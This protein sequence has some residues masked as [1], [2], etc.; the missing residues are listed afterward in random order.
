MVFIVFILFVI[1][2]RIGEMVLSR[3]N[4]VWL[5]QHGAIETGQRHYPAI[6]A[7]HMLFFVSL[8]VEYSTKQTV[9]FNVF[10]LVL[11]FILQAGKIWIVFSLG[12]FWNTKIYRI[13]DAPLIKKGPYRYF[14][15]PN[16]M[17]VVI[18][19]AVIPLMF[20]LVYTAIAF[21]LLN[22]IVLTVRIYEENKVI[23]K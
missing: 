2:L 11:F 17:I 20:Q 13:P 23:A 4:E 8:I 6:I 18:E 5:L 7:M 15:H 12:R 21:F 22:A 10:L 9:S 3:R 1:L 14:K 19:I 16:Y